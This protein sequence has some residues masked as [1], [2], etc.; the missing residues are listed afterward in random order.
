MNP[1]EPPPIEEIL[2]PLPPTTPAWVWA[3][4]ACVALLVVAGIIWWIRV[5]CAKRALLP[6][7][8]AAERFTTL[9]D[10]LEGSLPEGDRRAFTIA[11]SDGL[12]AFLAATEPGFPRSHTS[13]E[14]LRAAANSPRFGPRERELLE[15]FLASADRIKFAGAAASDD[16]AAELLRCA[17]AFLP[18]RPAA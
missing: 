17:R 6:T 7:P 3:A 16:A 10:S 12:R 9:L 18:H 5:A 8:S 14:C 15:A 1:P 4:V 2:P 11:V 13:E